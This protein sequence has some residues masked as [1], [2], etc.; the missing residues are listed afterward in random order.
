MDYTAL[1]PRR[2]NL[3]EEEVVSGKQLHVTIF[4]EELMVLELAVKS[5]H[6][7]SLL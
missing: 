7:E 4:L 1:C 3:I 5:P 2:R 6:I